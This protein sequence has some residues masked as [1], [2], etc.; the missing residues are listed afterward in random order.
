ME[1]SA[2]PSSAGSDAVEEPSEPNGEAAAVAFLPGRPAPRRLLIVDDEEIICKYLQRE[3]AQRGYEASYCLDGKQAL[4]QLAEAP[5]SILL[6]DMKMPGMTGMALLGRAREDFPGVS[7]VIVTAHGSIETAV[8][9][10]KLGASDYLTKPFQPEEL[11]LVIEKVLAQRK[12]LDEVAQL[13]HELAG[14]Y[15][16]ENM[17]SQDPKMREIFAQIARVAA[18]DATVV[19]TGETGTGKEL[20]ARALHYNS[21]RRDRQF[22]AL[23]CGALPDTLLE[24][25]LFG[26]EEGAFTGAVGAKPGIFEVAD[27]GTLLL[28]EIGDAT[29]ACQTALLRVL[30]EGEIRRV[31]SAEATPVNIRVVAATH[32][33]LEDEV[34]RGRFRTDLYYRLNVVPIHVPPLRDRPED[35]PLLIEH[36]LERR[37]AAGRSFS[38]DAIGILQRCPWPG[39][40]RELDNLVGRVL[41]LNLASIIRPQHLPPQYREKPERPALTTGSL[42]EAREAFERDYMKDLLERVGGNVAEAARQAGIGRPYLHQKLRKFGINPEVFRDHRPDANLA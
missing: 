41:V 3:L 29:P 34:R 40:V 37:G 6:A 1:R 35:I 25:E 31:G 22:V 14:R 10:M 23:N 39:N 13:R 17:I 20:V 32:R 4:R 36:F 18:T 2:E 38:D 12:L 24:T 27:G 30:Q 9:A 15:R 8:E 7:V 26:H 19:I 28:D 33:D 42:R 11:A 16:F 5:Y 21:S